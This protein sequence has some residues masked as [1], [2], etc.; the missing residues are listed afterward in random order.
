M[1][2]II[3]RLRDA[4]RATGGTIDSVRPLELGASRTRT[5]FVP[6]AAATAVTAAIAGGSMFVAGGGLNAAASAPAPPKFLVDARDG[7]VVRT[8]DGGVETDRYDDLGKEEWFTSV[9]AAQDNRLFYVASSKYMCGSNLYRLLLDEN[10]KILEFGTAPSTPPE[11]NRVSGLA[12]SGDGTKLAYALQP[13]APGQVA[14]LVIAD[15]ATGE[16]RTWKS[17]DGFGVTDLSMSADGRHVAFRP[18]PPAGMAIAEPPV[19]VATPVPSSSIV[20]LP[21]G[22]A[23]PFPEPAVT[24]TPVPGEAGITVFP[25]TTPP[26]ATATITVIPTPPLPDASIIPTLPPPDASI[27]AFPAPAITVTV[28]PTPME[29]GNRESSSLP[30]TAL[31]TPKPITPYPTDGQVYMG[32]PSGM[33]SCRFVTLPR[34]SAQWMCSEPGNIRVLDTDAPGDNLDKARTVSLPD[35][36]E[37]LSG[38]L[39]GVQLSPDGSRLLGMM[40]FNAV[41]VVDGTVRRKESISGIVAF[42]AEDGHA[43]EVL[44]RTTQT[45]FAQLLDLDGTGENLLVQQG[46]KIGA[47]TEGAYRPLTTGEAAPVGLFAG[48]LAW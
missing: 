20:P 22:S 1:N 15:T 13:C 33:S 14:G 34:T 16:S 25:P 17:P 46:A 11:G 36:Y 43:E 40:G 32:T 39:F 5:W 42:S 47:V 38:G 23:L 41:E 45:V 3:D 37:G 31:P 10:G 7:I 6:V 9:Q 35:S 21:S 30:P 2:D 4:T 8:V 28:T 27:T 48:E 24:L 26:D 19:V 12:V 18:G 44:Y 29:E